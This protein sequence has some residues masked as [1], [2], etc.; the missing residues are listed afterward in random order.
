MTPLEHTLAKALT[1]IV[2][3]LDLSDDDDI[4]IKV[5]EPVATL[6]QSLPKED[7]QAL[8]DLINE[9]AP[10]ETDPARHLTA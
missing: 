8:A 1:E 10:E 3:K 5:L 9:F 6:L 7:R 4:T 2:I